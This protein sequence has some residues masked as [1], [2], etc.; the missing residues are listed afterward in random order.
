M[1]TFVLRRIFTS[2][3][4]LI[5][6]LV[7]VYVLVSL[8][9]VDPVKQYAGVNASPERKEQVKH[10]L[11]LDRS[12]P[13]Q[14]FT[15]GKNFL[16]GRWGVSLLSKR[17]VREDVANTLPYTLELVGFA[18]ILTVVLGIL[19]GVTSAHKKDRLPDHASRVLAVGLIS[20]PTFWLALGLQYIFAGKLHVLPL[21]GANDYATMVAYPIQSIT[22]LPLLDALLTGNWVAF[23]DHFE[24][25]IL[26][27]IA[28]TGMA[29]GG[30]QRLTR[31]SMIE[32][33][34]EDYVV[35]VR[36][37][38]VPE[39]NVL[40]RHGLKNST[41]VLAT[42]IALC[43]AWLLVNTFLVEAIFAW[44]GMGS[45]I[46]NAVTGLDYPA[47]LAVTLL[48]AVSYLVVNTVADL[49]VAIDPRVRINS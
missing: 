30:L 18:L 13:V 37:Y 34:N 26:P 32:V 5:G 46:V 8:A 1:A 25:L 48:S 36:S 17:S 39:R 22:R 4:A 24:H 31:A 20:I 33:L 35:A 42:M 19:L 43:A 44:P 21:S 41:P 38:G 45:Y 23:W 3:I 28:L 10:E 40:W 27:V 2:F 29:L 12:I 9:P 6:V 47:L 14:M 16:T 15:Y 11:G 7:V 49:V